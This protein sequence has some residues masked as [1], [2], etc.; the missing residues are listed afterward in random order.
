MIKSFKHKGMERFFFE[1]RAKGIK[2]DH[3]K[4]IRQVLTVL[5]AAR[6]L[7][8]IKSVI[9][10]RCHSLTGHRKKEHA[11]WVNKNWRITFIFDDGNVYLTNYEDY[12]DGKLR[13]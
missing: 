7:D 6:E 2:A 12:H 8:D 1:G 4:K 11:V 5:D 10:L 9:P 13:R 3:V